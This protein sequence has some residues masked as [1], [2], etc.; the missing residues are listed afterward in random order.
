VALEGVVDEAG[1][2]HRL[3]HRPHRFPGCLDSLGE[4]LQAARV[5]EGGELFDQLPFIGEQADVEALATEIESGVQHVSGP[6]W[7]SFLGDTSVPPGGPSSWQS[8]AAVSA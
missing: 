7:C 2:G 5:R 6:P 1:P 4:C 3:D 8:K